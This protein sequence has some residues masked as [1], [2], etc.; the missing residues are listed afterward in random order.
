MRRLTP[1]PAKS[2]E[3]LLLESPEAFACALLARPPLA[4]QNH[5]IARD[6]DETL[7]RFALRALGRLRRMLK[8]PHQIAS[9]SYLFGG[10]LAD[11]RV[12]SRLLGA[13]VTALAHQGAL[14]VVGPRDSTDAM[15]GYLDALSPRL[16]FGSR[17]EARISPTGWMIMSAGDDRAHSPTPF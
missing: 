7:R 17:I 11:D 4:E 10:D 1:A 6:R 16:P 5:I 12:R 15:F 14:R 3:I 13:L 9:I 8:T 2:V